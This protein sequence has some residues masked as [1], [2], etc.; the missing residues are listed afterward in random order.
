MISMTSPS[1]DVEC[2]H[3]RTAAQ[4]SEERLRRAESQGEVIDLASGSDSENNQDVKMTRGSDRNL[5]EDGKSVGA[6]EPLGDG[7]LEDAKLVKMNRLERIK[8][9]EREKKDLSEWKVIHPG[10][11]YLR[12]G[13][14]LGSNKVGVIPAE[15]IV[16]VVEIQGRRARIVSPKIGWLSLRRQ[17]DAILCTPTQSTSRTPPSE[18]M[19]RCVSIA[20]D[21]DA[22]QCDCIRH[23]EKRLEEV[24]TDAR[25]AVEEVMREL[26]LESFRIWERVELLDFVVDPQFLEEVVVEECIDDH[27]VDEGEKVNSRNSCTASSCCLF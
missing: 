16:T 27:Q 12:E 4:A 14:E 9:R 20:P 18:D 19:E 24:G 3:V 13:E 2:L 26:G 17:N 10:G 15:T 7:K 25:E 5:V 8:E 23:R 6:G 21:M 22:G 1:M 11:L